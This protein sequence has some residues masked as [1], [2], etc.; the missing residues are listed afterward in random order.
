MIDGTSYCYYKVDKDWNDNK[1]PDFLGISE[2]G[3]LI[4]WDGKRPECLLLSHVHL[5]NG[6]CSTVICMYGSQKIIGAT[7]IV[8]VASIVW[9]RLGWG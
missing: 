6:H 4:G 5:T 8:F 7:Y 2:G 3:G 1:K 9:V